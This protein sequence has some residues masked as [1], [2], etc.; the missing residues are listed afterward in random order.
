M[1]K[2]D[3]VDPQGGA[4]YSRY[5][6]TR[7]EN[8]YRELLKK[9]RELQEKAPRFTGFQM[10][11]VNANTKGDILALKYSHNPNMIITEKVEKR[12]P[13][14]RNA[15]AP[16]D[17]NDFGNRMIRHTE[18]P[19]WKKIDLP[20]S[21]SQEI[22]W[23]VARSMSYDTLQAHRAQSTRAHPVGNARLEAHRSASYAHLKSTQALE[24][25]TLERTA[26]PNLGKSRSMPRIIPHL[27]AD[28]PQRPEVAK[29]NNRSLPPWW[30]PKNM[31]EIT[32]YA[33][34][35]VKQMAKN[36]FAGR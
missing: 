26:S 14:E 6:R 15:A 19:P 12:T 3:G 32:R 23:L 9:E 33:D 29:L 4:L 30:K 36:P 25:S 10:N 1:L 20:Q 8:N 35:Y 5:E 16:I 18:Q 13:A 21:R 24:G 28:N 2:D 31:C 22:G 11:L 7:V 17:K 34:I 27:P